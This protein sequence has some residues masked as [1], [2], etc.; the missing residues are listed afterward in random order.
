LA[1]EAKHDPDGALAEYES[2]VKLKPDDSSA[3]LRLGHVLEQKGQVSDAIGVYE[4]AARIVSGDAEVHAALGLALKATGEYV[5]ARA[6]L[7]EA[8]R[9]I[10]K[11][12]AHQ[13]RREQLQQALQAIAVKG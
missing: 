5:A 11:E 12:P 13:E 3:Y 10:P 8:L 4:R 1:L 2:V 6:E 9:L 7:E